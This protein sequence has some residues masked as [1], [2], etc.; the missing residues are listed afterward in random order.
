MAEFRQQARQLQDS[1]QLVQAPVAVCFSDEVPKGIAPY[2]GDDI[3]AG[4]EFWE[5]ASNSVF[6]TSAAD[7]A[8]CSIGVYTH[9]LADAPA[10][11]Q[12]ELETTLG[13]MV[14][15]DYV[16]EQEIRA[17]PVVEKQSRY[18]IYGPLAEIL[19]KPD[20]VVLFTHA[21]QSLIV[22]EATERVDANTPPAMGRPAC[23]VIPQV[24]NQGRAAMSLGCCGARAYLD[25][26]SDSVALWA[27]PGSKLEAYADQV[28]T[29]A[30]ANKLLTGFHQQRR[31]DVEAGRHP[32]VEES[33][34][35]M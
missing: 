13:T 29:L 14:K 31:S 16:R 32:T 30:K 5:R 18:V 7:H 23:A 33:L 34:Q 26:L 25:V 27:L 21:Q 20:A 28:E 8:L 11:Q 24:I 22:S 17:I 2:S 15:V 12:H 3:A 6:A 19:M 35:R 4:C 1:L 9:N 10:T